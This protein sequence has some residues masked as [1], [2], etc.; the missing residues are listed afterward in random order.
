MMNANCIGKPPC[1]GE[2]VRILVTVPTLVLVCRSADVKSVGTCIGA[3]FVDSTINGATADVAAWIEIRFR[4]RDVQSV[5]VINHGFGGR[6]RGDLGQ[7]NPMHHLL[8]YRGIIAS[9]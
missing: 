1:T 3:L 4:M 6:S 5:C 2:E 9:K 7:N 8:L